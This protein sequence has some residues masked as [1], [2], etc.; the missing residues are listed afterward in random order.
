MCVII[1][2][3]TGYLSAKFS[4]YIDINGSAL[5]SVTVHNQSFLNPYFCDSVLFSYK[6]LI[7][8]WVISID[9]ICT[10]LEN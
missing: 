6:M 3:T 1:A 4:L 9:R 8:I 2:Y 7:G 10:I 5:L